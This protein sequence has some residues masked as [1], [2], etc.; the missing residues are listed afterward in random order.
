VQQ[1][2]E[3]NTDQTSDRVSVRGAGPQDWAFIHAQV[4]QHFTGLV[5]ESALRHWLC[6]ESHRV[7]VA[8]RG[9]R[10]AGFIH[11]QPRPAAGELWLNLIAVHP[12]AR[13]G[14]V[15]ARLLAHCEALAAGQGLTRLALQCHV[16]NP[17]GLAFYARAGFLR[18]ERHHDPEIGQAFVRHVREVPPGTVAEAFGAAPSVWSGRL[19]GLRY[20][21]TIGRTSSL[22]ES[23]STAPIAR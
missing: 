13:R 14:G 11:V 12:E 23:R 20:N 6:Q 5:A 4:A 2:V 16:G 22:G 8:E 19:R 17:Q 3:M 18:G 1:E 15:A 7:F 21:L 10:P 9:G